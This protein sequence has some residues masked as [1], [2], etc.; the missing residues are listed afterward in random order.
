VDGS[1]TTQR[2][3]LA[4]VNVS[5]LLAPLSSEQLA[6]F[7][8]ASGPIEVAG[9]GARGFVWRTHVEVPPG[10]GNRPF[11]WDVGDSAGLVVNLSV[12]ESLEALEAFVHS[13]PHREV[14]HKRHSWFLRHPEASSALW[15]VPVGRHQRLVEAEQRLRHLRMFG[16]TSYAFT[17]AHP[18]PSD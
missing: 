1:P 2:L 13:S 18:F 3:H 6:G 11:D 5:R 15:W 8:A 14:L 4:Q 17:A 7:V 12:W 16:P 10:A 9:A